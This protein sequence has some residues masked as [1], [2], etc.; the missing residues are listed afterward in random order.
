MA[1]PHLIPV[2]PDATDG[3]VLSRHQHNCYCPYHNLEQVPCVPTQSCNT[4]HQNSA[5]LAT[6]TSAVQHHGDDALPGRRPF[7]RVIDQEIA[8]EKSVARPFA[9]SEERLFGIGPLAVPAMSSTQ[10]SDYGSVD[11]AHDGMNFNPT[12]NAH[13]SLVLPDGTTSLPENLPEEEFIRY[14]QQLTPAERKRQLQSQ[15]AALLEEQQYLR[16]V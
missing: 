8:K 14:Y 7:T 13:S 12:E 15:K 9:V 2:A 6:T 16:K 1:P 5:A 10:R 3:R 11:V 4:Y